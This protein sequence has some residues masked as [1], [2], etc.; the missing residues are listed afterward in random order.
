MKSNAKF[1]AAS[2]VDLKNSPLTPKQ[3]FELVAQQQKDVPIL[4]QN[5]ISADQ[6][7]LERIKSAMRDEG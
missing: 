3:K 5:P 4:M 7:R 6:N 1:S 2:K